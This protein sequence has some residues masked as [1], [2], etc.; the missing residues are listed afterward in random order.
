VSYAEKTKVSAEKSRA[1]IETTLR[2]YGAE[3]FGYYSR[4]DAA[5]VTF[6]AHGRKVL[7]S[8]PLPDRTEK[9]FTT[10]LSRGGDPY[11]RTE[12][13]ALAA[14][15]QECRQRWRALVLAIKSKL[16][17]VASGIAT[18]EQEFLAHILLPDG[19]TV[20]AWLAPQLDLAYRLG[21]MPQPALPAAPEAATDDV[22]ESEVI[23]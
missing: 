18:F 10:Y 13:S 1:E 20:G 5:Y 22:V 23:Q 3:D 21:K 6:V 16:E 11:A 14:W 2:R 12:S 15:D 19:L 8:L 17:S 9:R 4:K 7:F